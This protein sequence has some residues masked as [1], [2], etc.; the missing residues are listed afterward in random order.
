MGRGSETSPRES[1][2]RNKLE[3]RWS[4]EDRGSLLRENTGGQESDSTLGVRGGS[5]TTRGA[6]RRGEEK[7]APVGATA[8]L[9]NKPIVRATHDIVMVASNPNLRYAEHRTRIIIPD[10]PLHSGGYEEVRVTVG[11]V[12][13]SESEAKGWFNEWQE[14][15]TLGWEDVEFETFVVR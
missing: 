4:E 5:V 6:K 12:F 11:P 2:E 14:G 15:K 10:D 7:T 13:E 8:A 1:A 3:G 9:T